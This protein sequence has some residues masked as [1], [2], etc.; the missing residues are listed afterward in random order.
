MKNQTQFSPLLL[1]VICLL[2]LL[3]AFSAFAGGKHSNGIEA[4]QGNTAKPNF[5]IVHAK[6]TASGNIATFHMAISGKAGASTPV[7]TGKVAGSE[8]FAYVWPTTLNAYDVGFEKDAGILALAVASHPDFDDTPLF[9]ENGDTNYD[10][11][12]N[13]WH[14]HWV[15]L[16]PDDRCGEGKLAVKDIPQGQTPRLPRTWPGLPILIDSP[17]YDPVLTGESVDIR[18]PFPDAAVIDSAGY[19]AVTSGLRVNA[20]LHAPFFCVVDVFDVASGDL[21]LPGKVNQ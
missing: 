5:D 2:F 1:V 18:V 6:V 9:D 8:A 14:S 15:V 13:V 7:A 21:S 20:N 3:A 17:G 16:T 19:D 11:D 12:G 10:N 4:K